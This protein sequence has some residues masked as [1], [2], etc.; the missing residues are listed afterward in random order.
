MALHFG[1]VETGAVVFSDERF[2]VVK[3]VE[4]EIEERGGHGLAVNQH[5]LFGEVPATGTDE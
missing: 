2:D 1:E 3:E 5:V 4:A